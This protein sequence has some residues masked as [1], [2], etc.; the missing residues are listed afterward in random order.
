MINL[1]FLKE[2][3]I[4]LI[5][6]K[7]ALRV[8]IRAAVTKGLDR[9]HPLLFD[10]D[11]QQCLLSELLKT[12]L[13]DENYEM[14][15]QLLINMNDAINGL[16]QEFINAEVNTFIKEHPE[17]SQKGNF[18]VKRKSHFGDIKLSVPRFRNAEFR[19]CILG[20][21]TRNFFTETMILA[22]I[23]ANGLMSYP[24]IQTYFKSFNVSITND[25][26]ARV[27]NIIN[28][29]RKAEMFKIENSINSHQ[30][31]VFV[32]GVWAPFKVDERSVN[33][34]TG[35]VFYKKAKK[36]KVILNAIGIDVNGKKKTLASVT[37]DAEDSNGYRMLLNKLKNDK[38][39]ET[40]GMIVSDG[41]YALNDPLNEFYP[42]AKRQRC[43]VHVMRDIQRALSKQQRKHMLND[44]WNIFRSNSKQEALM[45]WNELMPTLKSTNVKVYYKLK[46]TIE[47]MLN[48]YDLP[49]SLW[50]SCYTNNISE[51][52]NS[53]FRRFSPSN[54]CFSSIESLELTLNLTHLHLNSKYKSYDLNRL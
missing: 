21:K 50:R 42:D 15:S 29:Y 23:V 32:D 52:F 22:M 33:D 28:K 34:L 38:G 11:I 26:I 41:S 1:K 17:A 14:I 18:V 53:V 19:S 27:T 16:I 46:K 54:T 7:H 10:K 4:Q 9:M 44:I 39:I 12:N 3:E 8:L 51:N 45:R 20:V 6:F 31:V 5:K 24:Q 36:R 43:V 2:W 47:D 35:E 30:L 40:I 37:C 48:F 25:E 13:S 49:R